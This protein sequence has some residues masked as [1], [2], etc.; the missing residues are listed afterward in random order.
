M[1]VEECLE[2]TVCDNEVFGVT[3]CIGTFILAFE[4]EYLEDLQSETSRCVNK[5]MEFTSYLPP[6]R[7]DFVDAIIQ[8]FFPVVFVNDSVQFEHNIPVVAPSATLT[9][10]GR[11]NDSVTDDVLCDLEYLPG[12]HPFPLLTP[13]NL[14]I[15]LVVEGVAADSHNIK[16]LTILVQPPYSNLRR[17]ADD[18]CRFKLQLFLAILNYFAN[19]FGSQKGFAPGD[20][21]LHHACI[22]EEFKAAFGF[23]KRNRFGRGISMKAEQAR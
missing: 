21:D 16:I 15:R 10:R 13:S 9:M 6:E 8:I 11:Y 18:P 12:V 1:P 5:C 22:R 7:S 4:Q 20:V 3:E 17:I 14:E 19:E 2:L 23:F